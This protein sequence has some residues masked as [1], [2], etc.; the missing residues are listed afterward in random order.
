MAA[1]F[2]RNER[3][4]HTLQTTDPVHEAY[5]AISLDHPAS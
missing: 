3:S 4:G 5:L 1:H 2:L